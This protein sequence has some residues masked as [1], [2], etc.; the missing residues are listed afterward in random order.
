MAASIKKIINIVIVV[1]VII[2]VAGIF[3][4]GWGNIPDI[5]IGK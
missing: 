4:G 5:R 2:W 1:A 3:F